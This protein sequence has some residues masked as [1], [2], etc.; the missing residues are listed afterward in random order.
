MIKRYIYE[1]HGSALKADS[2]RKLAVGDA[3]IVMIL[4]TNEANALAKVQ[5]K[6]SEPSIARSVECTSDWDLL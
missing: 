5:N 6:L 4:D 1:I 2:T 3:D